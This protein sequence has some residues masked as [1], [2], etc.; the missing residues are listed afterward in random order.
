VNYLSK[1]KVDIVKLFVMNTFK[2]SVE[3]ERVL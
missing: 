3:S 2:I 1:L